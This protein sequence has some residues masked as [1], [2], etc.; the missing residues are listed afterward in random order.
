MSTKHKYRV[1]VRRRAYVDR[2][3]K[4]EIGLRRLGWYMKNG[5]LITPYRKA[6]TT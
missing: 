2:L 4:E 6:K 3:H 1:R 5:Q